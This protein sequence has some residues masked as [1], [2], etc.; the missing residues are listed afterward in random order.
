[1]SDRLDVMAPEDKSDVDP[2]R[3]RRPLGALVALVVLAVVLAGTLGGGRALL[4]DLFRPAPDYSGS[5][6]GSVV[7]QVPKGA[8]AADIGRILVTRDVVK[9]AAAFTNAARK[10][11]RAL[12]IQPGFYQLRLRMRARAALA[13]LLDP[14]SRLRG[15]VTVPEGTTVARTLELIAQNTE[16]KIADLKEAAANPAAL[17]LP[18]YA[19]NRL[20][21]FLF[22]ATYDVE[23]GTSAV[24]V[25][26][27]MVDR[28]EVAAAAVELEERAHETG[29]SPYQ[30]V[31]LASLVEGET[32]I[33]EDRPK[34]ARVALN[35]LAKG[36]RLEFDSTVQYA[37]GKPKSRLLTRD[38]A[39]DSPYNTYRVRG[40]PPT[41]ISSPGEDA[42]RAAVAPAAGDWLYFVV[43]DKAGHSGFTASYDEFLRFKEQ[44]RREVL[45]G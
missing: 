14:R 20:E 10:D 37:L 22:P 34:V 21:G 45:N 3:R 17:G 41:P 15:R 23:P 42:L 31:V 44:Y 18:A 43:I 39:V 33:A 4:R 16:V 6:S 7:I 12:G 24:E 19:R 13:L 11:D 27:M 35:R 1:M 36:M 25:L 30:L 5:G 32:G 2:P 29:L 9:S 8:S 28:F 40:L 26:S 38:T